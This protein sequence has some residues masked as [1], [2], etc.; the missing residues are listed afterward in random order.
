M[1][2]SET[3]SPPTKSAELLPFKFGTYDFA[4]F[5]DLSLDMMVV[6]S[7]DG[8][9]RHINASWQRVLGY[10]AEELTSKPFVE[11]V[12][13]DDRERTIY[14]TSKLRR[15]IPTIFFE[16]RYRRKD[17]SYIW[18]GWTAVVHDQS[19]FAVARDITYQKHQAEMIVAARNEG[20]AERKKYEKL[21][22]SI[23]GAVYTFKL[24]LDGRYEFPF[25]SAQTL[26]IIG[27]SPEELRRYPYFPFENT[28]PDDLPRLRDSIQKSAE[29][30]TQFDYLGRLRTS[31]GTWR[32]V[33]VRSLPEPQSDGTVLWD[34]IMFDVTKEVETEK[35]LEIA[36]IENIHYSKLSALGEMA[37]GIGH[38]INNPLAVIHGFAERLRSLIEGSDLNLKQVEDCTAKIMH[39]AERIHKIVQSLKRFSH[40][41]D[42]SLLEP[43]KV[44]QIFD[45]TAELCRERFRNSGVEFVVAISDEDMTINCVESEIV[46]VLINLLN[47]SFQAVEKCAERWIKLE[48]TTENER[49]MISV[50][51]SGAGLSYEVQEKLWQ[52]FFT[53]KSVG[54]GTGLGLSISRRLMEGN[55]G[56]LTYDK[57]S[58]HTRF[59]VSLPKI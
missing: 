17:G 30:L 48:A 9:F 34:G 23:P 18:V 52:P 5:F 4:R 46:Q 2:E 42:R 12:H 40:T 24:T 59:V 29:Q 51:D 10:T 58:P 3:T 45:E 14:E 47:N 57:I 11:F 49:V 36:R 21:V 19:I 8:Y 43:C 31:V 27:I 16:N 50:T 55:N 25:A 53:T 32:W 28:H 1:I 15:G 6:A 35:A 33:K 41:S 26:Q 22:N 44:A 54:S 38:E 39:N 20:E 56:S 7:L 37:A 13:P